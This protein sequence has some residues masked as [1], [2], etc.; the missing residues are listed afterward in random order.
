MAELKKQKD[1]KTG[2]NSAFMSVDS[3]QTVTMTDLD[4]LGMT[5][6]TFQQGISV[7]GGASSVDTN[8]APQPDEYRAMCTVRFHPPEMPGALPNGVWVGPARENV[9]DAFGDCQA[10]ED[11]VAQIMYRVGA[12]LVGPIANPF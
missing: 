4:T 8:A 7:S 11:T 1:D 2:A 6:V 10:H 3:P 5:Y 9:D 12:A